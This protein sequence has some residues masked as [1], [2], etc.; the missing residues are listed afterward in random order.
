MK[1]LFATD[2]N[3]KI[4]Q[5]HK[6]FDGPANLLTAVLR[7]HMMVEERLFDVISAGVAI[8]SRTFKENDL[9]TFGT[10]AKLAQAIIGSAEM[11]T[12][13]KRLHH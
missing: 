10:A 9:F 3:A 1:E 11:L 6:A 12:Y 8:Y 7:V 13:G 5:F 4:A 2:L